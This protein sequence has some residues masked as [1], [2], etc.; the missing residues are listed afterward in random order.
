M[1]LLVEAALRSLVLGLA[2]GLGLRLFRVRNPQVEMTA[3]IVVLAAGLAMPLLMQWTL[4]RLPTALVTLPHGIIRATVAVPMQHLHILATPAATA[5]SWSLW[6]LVPF[7]YVTVVATLA[8][9]L[10]TGLLMTWRIV[11]HARPV[12]A[13]WT[14]GADVRV[15]LRVKAPVSFGRVILVP[16]SFVSWSAAKRRAVMEHERSHV[17]HHDFLV[18]VS[19][20]LHS[21]IFWFSPFAWWLQVRLA[22]LAE[23][24]SDEAA[25]A[26]I[27]NRVDYAEILLDIAVGARNLPSGIAMARPA[28]L[29]QRV[30]RILSQAAPIVALAPWRRSLLAASLLPA[31]LLIGGT[32]WQARAADLIAMPALPHIPAG[33]ARPI[34]DRLTFAVLFDGNLTMATG[35]ADLDRVLS[36]RDKVGDTA[37]LFLRDGKVYAVT[38]RDL[39]ERAAEL[40]QPPDALSDQQGDLVEQQADLSREQAE[41]SRQQADVGRQ[42]G[43]LGRQH[44]LQM[45]SRA[46]AVAKRASDEADTDEDRAGRDQD[47]KEQMAE[48]VQMQKDLGRAQGRLATERSKLSV[49]QSRIGRAQSRTDRN[50]DDA[51]RRLIDGAVTSGAATPVA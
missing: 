26:R 8:L 9:R 50:G 33:P 4:V 12:R 5:E 27:G 16:T 7:F 30:E 20:Q 25:I 37:I 44:G 14:R 2:V 24:T 40:Y 15:T 46:V 23:T 49:A 51:L 17:M 18:Q 36:A 35:G 28:L 41:L 43:E 29:R 11:R 3:W 38:D 48:L 39:V 1:M 32:S 10:L 19:S 22:A 31:V 42:M 21:A 45:A 6:S 34:A 47:F 13:D